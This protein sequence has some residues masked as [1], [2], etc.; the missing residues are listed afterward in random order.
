MSWEKIAVV[1]GISEHRIH[2]LM[3]GV[4]DPKPPKRRR[5]RAK[6]PAPARIAHDDIAAAR[7]MDMAF[8]TAMQQAMDAGL[9]KMP[10]KKM[11]EFKS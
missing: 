9:E 11:W 3:Y 1:L 2:R 7:K 4:P 8:C 10:A 5:H 6:E